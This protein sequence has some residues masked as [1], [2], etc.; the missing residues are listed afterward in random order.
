MVV[1]VT[2]QGA[3]AEPAERPP[4][5]EVAQG[6]VNSEPFG[7]PVATRVCRPWTYWWWMGNAVDRENMARVLELYREAGMGG[8]TIVPIYGVK[9]REDAYLAYLSPEWMTML[10]FTVAT[11]DRLDLGVDM[12]TGTGWPFGG[13]QVG[14][15]EAAAKLDVQVIETAPGEQ[16]DLPA[17]GPMPQAVVAVSGAGEFV[18]LTSAWA[19][20]GSGTGTSRSKTRSLVP[21][22]GFVYIVRQL[23]T[24]QQVKRAAPGGQG[25]VLDPYSTASLRRYLERFDAAFA[26]Y[27]APKPRAQYHDSFEYY[28]TNWTDDFLAAFRDRRGYDLLPHLPALLDDAPDDTAAR[29]TSDYRE[30]VAELL[31]DYITAWADWSARLGCETRNQAHGS[32]GNILDLYAAA[33]IPETEIFGASG[34]EI[35]GLR[36]D[37][38]FQGDRPSPLMIKFASSAAHVAGKP[39]IASES[40]TWLAEHFRES[41]A[42]A[43][44]E[45]DQ[46][47][48][49]GVNH[50]F[51]HGIAYSPPDD[52]WPGWLFYASTHF[53]PSNT[54]WRDLPALN[55]YIA[56]CQSVLQSGAP[57]NDVLLYFPMYDIW[58]DAA[59]GATLRPLQVH[60]ISGWLACGG[61]GVVARLFW[62]R[63]YGFDY[64][65]D[66]LLASVTADGEG[67]RAPG[68]AYRVL[69][70][71]PCR[72][73]PLETLRKVF[74]LARSGATVI[75]LEALPSSAPGYADFERRQAEYDR[76]VGDLAFADTNTPGVRE[77]RLGAGRILVGADCEALLTAAGVRREVVADAGVRFIR[78]RHDA[79]CHYFL[80]NLGD[81]TLDGWVPLGVQARSAVLLDPCFVDRAG[82]AA[83]RTLPDGGTACYLQLAPGES[84][85]LRTF[86][87]REVAGR[88]WPYRRVLEDRP[89]VAPATP[90]RV[91]FIEGGPDL[92]PGFETNRLASWT[93]R[94]GAAET[95]AGTARYETTFELPEDGAAD[96]LLDFGRVCESARVYVNGAHVGT[97]FS[98][99][100]RLFIGEFARPGKNSLAV[101]VTNLAANRIRDMDRRNVAWKKF[102]DANFV[103]IRYK[104]FD[105]SDWPLLDSGL[106]GPVRLLPAAVAPDPE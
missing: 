73:L 29:I 97:L 87:E 43:K 90:W 56:R 2:A 96:W 57:D 83:V 26:G 17:E 105:A 55:A 10:E 40:C 81:H 62:E 14:P 11:A 42:Q 86:T 37:P 65:S 78:R 100:F 64:V 72:F 8:M 34:F 30:T 80:T 79:G 99:P 102:H 60:N 32:P 36:T 50:V 38:D 51:Y 84:L 25:N 61:L 19:R 18:D 23:P 77:A 59:A 22:P 33:T 3:G 31:L 1:L 15:D 92:P 93:T 89:A 82:V 85:V 9:G 53:G 21:V 104:P 58:H 39:L 24:G 63:G 67:L 91:T 16:I 94:G 98:L 69:V 88:A 49:A 103:N 47:F 74:E 68:G 70:L 71:P 12:S 66:R 95:F 46:L 6:D 4:G 106:L 27:G 45:I 5:R 35:P 101:E 28:H 13:P 54:I 41:L 44:P 7:W 20:L 48:A 75:A 52:P 76:L